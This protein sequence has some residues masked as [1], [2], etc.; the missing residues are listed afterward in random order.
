MNDIR[1]SDAQ[2]VLES[3][4]NTFRFTIGDSLLQA[5]NGPVGGSENTI[6]G[7]IEIDGERIDLDTMDLNPQY[8]D[9]D[10]HNTYCCKDDLNWSHQAP[11]CETR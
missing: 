5:T 9:E 8:D 7:W 10:F 3:E 4:G 2:V 11:R 1:V 6:S